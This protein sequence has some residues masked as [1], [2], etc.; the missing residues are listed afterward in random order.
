MPFQ[1]PDPTVKPITADGFAVQ[2]LVGGGVVLGKL[3]ADVLDPTKESWDEDRR[4]TLSSQQKGKL[5]I[6]LARLPTPVGEEAPHSDLGDGVYFVVQ[7][8]GKYL[9][10]TVRKFVRPYQKD[11]REELIGLKPGV[12]F[13]VP[14]LEALVQELCK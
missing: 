11:R 14:Q 1:I 9:N 12:T 7:R 5:R 4:I 13:S 2:H 6:A 8:Y 10:A 3:V